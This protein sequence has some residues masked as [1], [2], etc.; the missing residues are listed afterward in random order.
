MNFES[1]KINLHNLQD[2]VHNNATI[3][4]F[5]AMERTVPHTAML[6]VSELAGGVEGDRNG[7]LDRHLPQYDRLTIK[8]ADAVIRILDMA[9]GFGL[10]VIDAII[11]KHDFN[12]GREYLHGKKY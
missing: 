7:E 10:P 5:W 1:L 4:G 8:L 3:K 9:K 2:E 6:I 11:D 12:I